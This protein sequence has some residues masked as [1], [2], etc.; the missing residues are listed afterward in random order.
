MDIQ[1][2]LRQLT[3]CLAG[4]VLTGRE[5]SFRFEVPPLDNTRGL[6]FR[7]GFSKA[8]IYVDPDLDDQQTFR[9]ICHEIAHV[10]HDF[11]V[12]MDV[13]NAG[14]LLGRYNS[15]V[16]ILPSHRENMC[17]AQEGKWIYLAEELKPGGSCIEKLS[18][19]AKYYSKGRK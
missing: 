8:V 11:D 4:L 17:K 3:A 16:N 9:T 1:K 14:E 7:D 18:A 5:V 10:K 2:E 6:A 15:E 19:L 13:K 12:M